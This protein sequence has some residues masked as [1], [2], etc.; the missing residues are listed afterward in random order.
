M[1]NGR[2]KNMLQG[3]NLVYIRADKNE[4]VSTKSGLP[5][6][7]AN[8]T[9]SDGL[10]SFKLDLNPDIVPLL[11]T[12]KKGDKVNIVVDVREVFNRNQFMVTDVQAV[13]Q[14]V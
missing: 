4:G 10:E 9:L 6:C 5:Y 7:F 11:T 3:K 1:K 2:G 12:F 14:K 8:L 13:L